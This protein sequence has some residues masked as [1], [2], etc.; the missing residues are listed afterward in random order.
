MI[1]MEGKGFVKSWWWT[2]GVQDGTGSIEAEEDDYELQVCLHRR[3]GSY[4]P[5]IA[6]YY[7]AS[8]E[9]HFEEGARLW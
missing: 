7:I 3:R 2:R 4:V 9:Q 1:V 8:A 6:I 5:A